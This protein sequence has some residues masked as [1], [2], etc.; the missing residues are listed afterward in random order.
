MEVAVSN[1][2][3]PVGHPVADREALGA[4]QQVPHLHSDGEW[5]VGG[6]LDG[7]IGL[8]TGAVQA[9]TSYGVVRRKA[10]LLQNNM[11]SAADGQDMHPGIWAE[12]RFF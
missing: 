12:L 7:I 11:P 4:V 9:Q 10:S 1:E 5:Q 6:R 2:R 3:L 8:G